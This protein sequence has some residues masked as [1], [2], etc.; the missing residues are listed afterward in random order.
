MPLV[1]GILTSTIIRLVQKIAV[2]YS[3]CLLLRSPFECGGSYFS[4]NLAM[5]QVSVPICVHLYF[6]YHDGEDADLDERLTWLIAVALLVIW[7][8]LFSLFIFYIIL[9]ENRRTFWSFQTGWQKSQAFF[10]EN[11]EDERRVKIFRRTKYHWISLEEEVKVWTHASWS[12]WEDEKPAWFTPLM[13]ATIPDEFIPISALVKL[14]GVR[15]ERK[16]SA[17]LSVTEGGDLRRRLS[18][19]EGEGRVVVVE[20]VA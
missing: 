12:K 2:D 19:L 5:T 4:F 10:L 20:D 15:R 14:G 6:K 1:A 7:L 8:T 16:G 13:K 18:H 17:S 3:G 11:E 9:P